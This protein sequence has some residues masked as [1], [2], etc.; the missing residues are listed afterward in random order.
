[1]TDADGRIIPYVEGDQGEGVKDFYDID[2]NQELELLQQKFEETLEKDK[3]DS[4]MLQEILDKVD[5]LIRSINHVF[6]D[7][8][9]IKG[10]FQD[11]SDLEDTQK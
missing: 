7:H 1:M 8:V 5:I 10:R 6:G 2:P 9:L 4:E 11:I 3:S